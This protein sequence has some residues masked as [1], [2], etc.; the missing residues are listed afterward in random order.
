MQN[1][2]LLRE[3]KVKKKINGE[4]KLRFILK[5]KTENRKTVSF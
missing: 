5:Y 3:L 2:F 1:V 4:N